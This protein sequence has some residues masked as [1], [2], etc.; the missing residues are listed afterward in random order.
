MPSCLHCM[1]W[2]SSR[3]SVSMWKDRQSYISFY[4]Y[5]MAK[6][7]NH[8]RM[9]TCKTTLGVNEENDHYAFVNC[10]YF[11]CWPRWEYK[12][13]QKPT[14]GNIYEFTFEYPYAFTQKAKSIL[15]K[16]IAI[17]SGSCC[18]VLSYILFSGVLTWSSKIVNANYYQSRSSSWLA[19]VA[20]LVQGTLQG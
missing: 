6:I 8:L 13:G 11:I 17:N 19:I 4:L 20:L 5:L 2:F 15:N 9:H 10:V 14:S 12:N 16:H 1:S 7:N 3:L 18:I